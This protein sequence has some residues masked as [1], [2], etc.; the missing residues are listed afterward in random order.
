MN[1]PVVGALL[2]AFFI[3]GCSIGFLGRHGEGEVVIVPALPVTV[4]I[5]TDQPYY[6]NGYYYSRRGDVWYY[7]TS[8]EGPWRHLPRD[9]YPKEVR[10]KNHDNQS[11]DEHNQDGQGHDRHDDNR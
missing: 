6:Q 11:H 4:E 10:Y 5:D 3:S 1:K 9:H 2:F 7:S 8:Q